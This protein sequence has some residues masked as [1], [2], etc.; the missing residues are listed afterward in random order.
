MCVQ[1]IGVDCP[2]HS[3]DAAMPFRRV[4][5]FPYQSWDWWRVSE[6]CWLQWDRCSVGLDLGCAYNPLSCSPVIRRKRTSALKGDSTLRRFNM[7]RHR[8][9]SRQQF[10]AGV[11]RR[12]GRLRSELRGGLCRRGRP[13]DRSSCLDRPSQ[14]RLLDATTLLQRAASGFSGA[15]GRR[16]SIMRTLRLVTRLLGLPQPG[17][18]RTG[19]GR[20]R[21]T[22]GG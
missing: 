8:S 12:G 4:R 13:A 21:C 17:P 10:P 19:A 3:A 15:P 1:W 5:W 2:A 18:Q 22:C 11:C 20:R 14:C 16:H 9:R 6:A 7:V